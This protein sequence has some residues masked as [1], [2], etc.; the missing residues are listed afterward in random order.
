MIKRIGAIKRRVD[1]PYD[2][3]LVLQIA[4]WADR[5]RRTEAEASITCA[6]SGGWMQSAPVVH[7]APAGVSRGENLGAGRQGRFSCLPLRRGA[8]FF[9]GPPPNPCFLGEGRGPAPHRRPA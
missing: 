1:Q 8:R 2:K 7:L 6:D 9:P 5:L 3:V 4:P